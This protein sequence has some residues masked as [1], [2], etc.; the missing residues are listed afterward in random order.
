MQLMSR[1]NQVTYSFRIMASLTLWE[2]KK[3]RIKQLIF[4]NLFLYFYR[5]ALQF[6]TKNNNNNKKNVECHKWALQNEREPIFFWNSDWSVHYLVS[7]SPLTTGWCKALKYRA[8]L[9]FISCTVKISLWLSCSVAKLHYYCVCNVKP[10]KA[11]L[12]MLKQNYEKKKEI[13][14]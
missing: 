8:R 14:S 3:K 9:D 11:S 13:K 12:V 10:T 2:R 4:T 1:P 5:T 7:S 6:D